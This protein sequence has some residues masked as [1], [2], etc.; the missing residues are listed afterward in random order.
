MPASQPLSYTGHDNDELKSL[1]QV[2]EILAAKTDLANSH[3]RPPDSGF[4][5]AMHSAA[6][7]SNFFKLE[8][9]GPHRIIHED[10]DLHPEPPQVAILKEFQDVLLSE[11]DMFQQQIEQLKTAHQA[12]QQQFTSELKV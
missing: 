1:Q 2:R 11:R 9:T 6:F 7:E 8:Q 3:K 5:T 12:M 10:K 4:S